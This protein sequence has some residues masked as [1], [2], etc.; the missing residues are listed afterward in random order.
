M[1]PYG[2][3]LQLL[4]FYG[5]SESSF[6]ERDLS[7][8]ARLKKKKKL[9]SPEFFSP[10]RA[11]FNTGFSVHSTRR[12]S[13]KLRTQLRAPNTLPQNQ[14]DVAERRDMEE[15]GRRRAYRHPA[16]R[17]GRKFSATV[18]PLGRVFVAIGEP[19]RTRAADAKRNDREIWCTIRATALSSAREAY[20]FPRSRRRTKG[21]VCASLEWLL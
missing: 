16:S 14:S 17:E 20:P 4:V 12:F 8:T 18:V 10:P 5:R 21:D 13:V 3:R 6:S 9:I 11:P 2:A 7:V 19:E 15:K 1:K